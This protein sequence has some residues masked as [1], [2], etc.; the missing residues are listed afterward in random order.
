M[1]VVRVIFP[2]E[3]TPHRSGEIAASAACVILR[4]APQGARRKGW[5][6]TPMVRD[7]R[8]GAL[9]TIRVVALITERSDHRSSCFFD[10]FSSGEPV[11]T[12]DRVRG[13][14]SFENALVE[15]PA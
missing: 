8:E 1:T 10:A 12:P 2:A 7:A 9:L 4:I 13:R 15:S 3:K 6:D 11:S 5:T 14:L